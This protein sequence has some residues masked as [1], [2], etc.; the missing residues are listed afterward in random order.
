MENESPKMW[1]TVEIHEFYKKI[2]DK[3]YRYWKFAHE[4]H[5]KKEDTPLTEI[6]FVVLPPLSFNS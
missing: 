6:P 2:G 4:E 1:K 5:Y 3:V